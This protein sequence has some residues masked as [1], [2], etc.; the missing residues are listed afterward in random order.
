[1]D[2]YIQRDYCTVHYCTVKGSSLPARKR[3]KPRRL[4]DLT[5]LDLFRA[6]ISSCCRRFIGRWYGRTLY[7]SCNSQLRSPRFTTVHCMCVRTYMCMT[8]IVFSETGIDCLLVL[9]IPLTECS[10]LPDCSVIP[11]FL[12]DALS[13][14]P[15]FLP[16]TYVFFNHPSLTFLSQLIT[17]YTLTFVGLNFRGFGG[18]AAIQES[19]IPQK[20]A[21]I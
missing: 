5:A 9:D 17:V 15:C 19:F 14:F 16:H 12:L 18:P 7:R 21:P 6:K 3:A 8:I 20:F 2:T 10:F 1:M 13:R 4:V 11:A